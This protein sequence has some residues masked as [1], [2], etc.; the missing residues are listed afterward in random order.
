MFTLISFCPA[1]WASPLPWSAAVSNLPCRDP[2]RDLLQVVRSLVWTSWC[3]RLSCLPSFRS[4]QGG[5]WFTWFLTGPGA[6]TSAR[7]EPQGLLLSFIQTCPKSTA[8]CLRSP[9]RSRTLRLAGTQLMWLVLCASWN[10]T[11]TRCCCSCTFSSPT[12][13]PTR[14]RLLLRSNV[15]RF[16]SSLRH[17]HPCR[18][19]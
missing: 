9:L 4:T 13:L 8:C 14:R 1:T 10:T 5:T 11:V 2:P 7:L 15:L 17:S 19:P 6:K 16:H 3:C 12:L 18:V